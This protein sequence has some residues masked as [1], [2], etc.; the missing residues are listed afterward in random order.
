MKKLFLTL[1]LVLASLS[2]AMAQSA[3]H[4]PSLQ[5]W[6]LE[7]FKDT[8]PIK[9]Q[10]VFVANLNQSSI[11]WESVRDLQ[12]TLD[13]ETLAVN[14]VGEKD[15]HTFEHMVS[16][17]I[18]VGV[19]MPITYQALYMMNWNGRR[20]ID[21]DIIAQPT[22]QNESEYGVGLSL[23][24]FDQAFFVSTHAKLIYLLPPNDPWFDPKFDRVWGQSAEIG[25]RGVMGQNGAWAKMIGT[26]ELGST[27]IMSKAYDLRDQPR[28]HIQVGLNWLF[29]DRK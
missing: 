26:V 25:L 3:A 14:V 21:G 8:L 24:P 18:Q 11:A 9:E 20:F 28:V 29:F 10:A 6:T 12:V 23:H 5:V 22:R 19:F 1:I 13:K 4:A 17:G 15:K 2:Q 7:E 16:V 27:W